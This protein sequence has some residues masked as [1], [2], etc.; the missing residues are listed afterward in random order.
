LK[1]PQQQK[2]DQAAADKVRENLGKIAKAFD[3]GLFK[4]FGETANYNILKKNLADAFATAELQ[5]GNVGA[6]LQSKLNEQD[7][8]VFV[9]AVLNIETTGDEKLDEAVQDAIKS[10]GANPAAQMEAARKV[11]SD[12]YREMTAKQVAYEAAVEAAGVE[13]DTLKAKTQ[14]AAQY[15]ESSMGGE[16]QQVLTDIKGL[17]KEML[18]PNLTD[19]QATSIENRLA[20]LRGKV[21]KLFE[22]GNIS[23]TLAEGLTAAIDQAE[24]ALKAKS[25][26]ISI[27][28]EFEPGVLENL[29]QQI[30]GTM[31]AGVEGAEATATAIGKIQIPMQGVISKAG[32]VV[33][34]MN[35][36]KTAAE[37]ALKA[38]QAAAS[39]GGSSYHGGKV[40][41]RASG[42]PT[43]GQD[44]VMT[45]T[46]PGEF[47]TNAK[48]TRKFYSELQAMN[49]GQSPQY[50]DKGGPVTNNYGGTVGDVNVTV[51]GGASDEIARDIAS[52]IDREL[53]FG[54]SRVRR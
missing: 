16:A 1:S 6:A 35:A 47:I 13:T 45:A 4:A 43:R 37:A 44:T 8:K 41:Y 40:A 2:E 10:A 36:I 34:A 20:G 33:K 29:E 24:K 15:I 46:A 26:A 23:S 22:E 28:P 39:A 52:A 9:D 49:A 5:F 19:L 51:Q 7:Y 17:S 14:L 11:M 48:S 31:S 54:T 3:E 18:D 42:G 53:R 27:K 30:R 12:A 25:I 50:R 32:A 21:G 38:A